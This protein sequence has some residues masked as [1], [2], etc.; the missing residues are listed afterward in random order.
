MNKL[1]CYGVVFLLILGTVMAEITISELLQEYNLGEALAFELFVSNP[2]TLD[3]TVEVSLICDAITT[4][5]YT[6]VL[7]LD[8]G[9]QQ[10]LSIPPM[11]LLPL[12]GGE[13]KVEATSASFDQSFTATETSA[14]FT[15]EDEMQ[16]LIEYEDNVYS[17]GD[18]ITIEGTL[19]PGYE[20]FEGA[21]VV[22]TLGDDFTER[23]K[24]KTFSMTI[25]IPEIINSFEN[26]LIVHV[27]DDYGNIGEY[28]GF[29]QIAQVPN[30]ILL[31]LSKEAY[32]P[33]ET[34]R[35][36]AKYVDQA[37]EAIDETVTI[38]LYS[39]KRILS[40][41]LLYEG[42]IEEQLFLYQLSQYAVPGEYLIKVEAG[43]L[44]A[45]KTFIVNEHKDL[46]MEFKAN[47]LILKNVGNVRI[48][49]D[50]T[51]K[52]GN[53]DSLYVLSVNLAPG[54]EDTFDLVSELD[55]PAGEEVSIVVDALGD[56]TKFTTQIDDSDRK[57]FFTLTG[58]AIGS[59]P[60]HPVFVG[61]LLI[62]VLGFIV[63]FY[64]KKR[65]DSGVASP[66]QVKPSSP[67]DVKQ[68]PQKESSGEKKSSEPEREVSTSAQP[69]T[70]KSVPPAT[71]ETSGSSDK[72]GSIEPYWDEN[73]KK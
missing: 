4:N 22:I 66:I 55:L 72:S 42:E 70:K 48:K 57:G 39:I 8:K 73:E 24:K 17:P 58:A 25:V 1:V 5:Y 54:Q 34:V 23:I 65:S 49:E 7:S 56:S 20:E 28:E 60:E 38:K 47:Q 68:V 10:Q 62:I 27:E 50:V 69:E 43:D 12:T 29:V 51:V 61:I 35:L 18:R 30:E 15:V 19:E 46:S 21:D 9:E 37:L 40:R 44:K 31:D 16:L 59:I 6:S 63:A 53:E 67:S 13:C 45:E 3:G 26:D 14:S 36:L 33:S 71:E 64:V 2:E 52:Y 32:E 11:T 41:D